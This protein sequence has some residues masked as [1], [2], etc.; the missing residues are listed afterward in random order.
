M[1]YL[2]KSHEIHLVF[3]HRDFLQSCCEL[4]GSIPDLEEKNGEEYG[5]YNY[6]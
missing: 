2:G 1:H 6:L 3:K 4:A 5:L